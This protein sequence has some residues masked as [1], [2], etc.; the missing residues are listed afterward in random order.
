MHWISTFKVFSP[1]AS[2]NSKK[3]ASQSKPRRPY[4][5]TISS[6]SFSTFNASETSWRR[7]RRE[8]GRVTPCSSAKKGIACL[9][10]REPLQSIGSQEGA[11][12]IVSMIIFH[13]IADRTICS[14]WF[15]IE[16]AS[17]IFRKRSIQGSSSRVPALK[18]GW[19]GDWPVHRSASWRFRKFKRTK[20]SWIRSLNNVSLALKNKKLSVMQ[21]RKRRS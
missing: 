11:A 6:V 13:R 12:R 8:A 18:T 3:S 5:A 20:I 14:T 17:S 4:T 21:R 16:W 9:S 10:L 19:T 7:I 15:K 1:R 2:K